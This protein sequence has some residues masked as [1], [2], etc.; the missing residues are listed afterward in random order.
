[1][2]TPSDLVPQSFLAPESLGTLAPAQWDLLIRQARRANVLAKLAYL[3]ERRGGSTQVLPAAAPHLASAATIA[4]QQGT[5]I[6]WEVSCIRAA[7]AQ[8]GVP[9][10]L[11]KG[12]AYVAAGLPAADGRVFNDVDI[13]VPKAAIADV[14]SALMLH[15]WISSHHDAY[16]QRYYRQ[17]MHEIPP[18]QHVRRGT[19]IDVHHAILPET[20]RIRADSQAMLAAVVPVEGWDDVFVFAPADM[21]LHSATHLFH[22]GELDN[23]LRDLLDM[24]SLLRHFAADDAFW[25]GLVPRAKVLGLTRPLFYALRYAVETLATPVPPAVM[26]ALAE[27]G[28]PPAWQ[29]LVM[30]ACFRRAL[31]PNHPSCA[32]RWTPLARWWLYVRSHWL[33]MPLPLLLYH[34]TRKALM[35]EPPVKDE[36][37]DTNEKAPAH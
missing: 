12:A 22:E 14:E 25:P 26:Q 18:M 11:L 10:V 35:S 2:P 15:G 8:T 7:L 5:A 16:D 37:A 9:L 21:I 13:L 1:M 23:G 6:R 3:L 17:W 20:A 30:D 24:D 34:L 27:C 28:R 19:V 29:L 33:R 36:R 4:L 32:D 31:R